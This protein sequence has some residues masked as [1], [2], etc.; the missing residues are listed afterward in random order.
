MLLELVGRTNKSLV[1]NW[2]DA[3][4]F[5]SQTLRPESGIIVMRLL[6]TTNPFSILP[7]LVKSKSKGSNISPRLSEKSSRNDTSLPTQSNDSA[8]SQCVYLVESHVPVLLVLVI[9][10]E[11]TIDRALFRM[12]GAYYPYLGS[13]TDLY[14]PLL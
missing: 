4:E 9:R 8:P 11:N 13:G 2:T 14:A 5:V 6:P 7:P 12:S 10:N 3:P 1:R